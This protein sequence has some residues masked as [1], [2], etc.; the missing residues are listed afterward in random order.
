MVE[1]F[2]VLRRIYNAFDPFRPLPAKDPAYES[3]EEVRGDVNIL[4]DLGRGIQFAR[5][6]RSP[7]CQLYAGHR[8][9]GKSTELLRL[10]QDLRENQFRV[11]YFAADEE[12]I[13]AEDAQYTDIL[14]ACT[15]HI[16]QELKG[17]DQN[18]IWTWLQSRMR[19]LAEI[20]GS[21]LELE[22]VAI[23]AQI[24]QL[25]KITATLRAS[26][27]IRQRIRREVEPYTVS[28][29]EALNQYIDQAMAKQPEQTPQRLVVIVDNLDRIPFIFDPDSNRS[30]H[31]QI[32]FDRSEQLK[33]LNC[34]VI[35]TVPISLLNSNRA[36]DL[37]TIYGNEKILPIVM[38]QTD[39]NQPHPLGIS[40]LKELIRKRIDLDLPRYALEP[41]LSQ[42]FDLQQQTL[43]RLCLMSGGHV[44]DLMYLVQTATRYSDQLPISA[45][46]VQRAIG[47][48]R[49][50]Y[51]RTVDADQW[52][53]LAEVWRTKES[54]NT[55]THRNL[56]F[57]R[58][59]LEYREITDDGTPR[60][61]YDVHPLL[62][63][64][65]EFK[66]ALAMN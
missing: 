66:A 2:D 63:G 17:A 48:V 44:R 33:A 59:I 28:L 9:A 26:P 3:L 27:T 19:S 7:I 12:D 60:N 18:P 51:R 22:N 52:E 65:D 46:A 53:V 6:A 20:L 42:V 25:A 37:Q 38:V 23:E 29:I 24:S 4:V 62:T 13:D 34:H 39:D 11:V 54:P 8:G 31:D 10:A 5:F 64:L 35:Y 45:R 41:D 15:R 21:N 14:L 58:C 36:A 32:F 55:E 49:S 43:E 40:K 1:N 50:G 57:R 61:W 47:E 16:L 30:N 56:L